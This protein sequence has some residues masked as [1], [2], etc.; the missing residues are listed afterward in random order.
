MLKYIIRRLLQQIPILIG[1]SILV[2]TIIQIAPGD[3]L[4]DMYQ[5]PNISA[6]QIEKVR[7][8]YG[9]NKSKPEQYFDYMKGVV[10]GDMGRSY[11]YKVPVTQLIKERIKP[12]IALAFF[13]MLVS[14]IIAIP[15]GVVSATKQYSIFDYLGTIFALAGMSIPAFFFG[16]LLKKWLAVDIRLFPLNGLTTPATRAT[17]FALLKEYA[18]HLFLPVMMLGLTGA[19]GYM[20]YMRSS[21]LEVIRQDYVRTARAKGLKE[22]TVVYRHALRNAMIPVVTLLGFQIPALVSGATMTEIIFQLPGMGR[23]QYQAVLKRDWPVMLGTNLFLALF[24]LMGNLI[25]DVSYAAV[26]PRIRLD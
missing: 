3:P 25:A 13:S 23:L 1:I 2:F 21:M 11:Q 8:S 12:T 5:N 16:L 6:E 19:G 22:R 20:R 24:T 7:E 10:Q 15:M 18:N 4:V 26:D 17:G 9:L 14:L